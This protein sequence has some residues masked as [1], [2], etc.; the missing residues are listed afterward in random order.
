MNIFV[1]VLIFFNLPRGFILMELA[2]RSGW[3]E[4]GEAA[5]WR[6]GSPPRQLPSRPA[7]ARRAAGAGPR[8][9]GGRAG[10]SQ[11]HL[12]AAPGVASA[13]L[14]GR[15]GVGR[16]GGRGARRERR[17]ALSLHFWSQASGS[18]RGRPLG[19][20]A[21]VAAAAAAAPPS[22]LS[23]PPHSLVGSGGGGSAGESGFCPEPRRGELAVATCRPKHSPK[24]GP[25]GEDFRLLAEPCQ[26]SWDL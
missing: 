1:F 2:A 16:S 9:A 21:A 7:P 17:A 23:F 10:E 26:A 4:A 12:S 25:L 20:A 14:R 19:L 24:S 3:G 8:E 11:S 22:P 15:A 5:R 18:S 13:A 6:A